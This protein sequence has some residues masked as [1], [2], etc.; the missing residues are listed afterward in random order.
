M[1]DAGRGPWGSAPQRADPPVSVDST[2]AVEKPPRFSSLFSFGTLLAACYAGYYTFLLYRDHATD[3]IKYAAL[4]ATIIALVLSCILAQRCL[5]KSRLTIWQLQS[6]KVFIATSVFQFLI[7]GAYLFSMFYFPYLI[8]EKSIIY[9]VIT[10]IVLTHTYML[11]LNIQ[12]THLI[13]FSLTLGAFELAASVPIVVLVLLYLLA[14][15]TKN[16]NSDG[17]NPTP[18]TARTIGGPGTFEAVAMLDGLATK[19]RVQASDPATAARMLEA[20][21]G[22]G[23]FYGGPAFPYRV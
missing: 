11:Y 20:Q 3:E 7:A 2:S 14:R 22:R 21:Y 9:A 18:N 13:F 15:N 10:C 12:Q 17:G 5:T 1:P 4:L 19:V 6:I 16:Q 8:L 23:A